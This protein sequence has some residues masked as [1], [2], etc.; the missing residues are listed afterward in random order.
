LHILPHIVFRN[1]WAWG[2]EESEK[3]KPAMRAQN[4]YTIEVDHPKFGR[5]YMVF[6][7]APGVSESASDVEPQLLFTENETNA[8]VLYGQK[9]N[10][11]YVKDAFHDYVVGGKSD[12]VNP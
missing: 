3:G 8:K 4:N 2:T 9:N 10:A 1:T 6:A 11:E 12:A 7:P 5:R